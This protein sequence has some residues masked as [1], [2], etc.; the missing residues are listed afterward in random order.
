MSNMVYFLKRKDNREMTG[1]KRKGVLLVVSGFS[2]AGKGTLVQKLTKEFDN[3]ALS[4]SMTTRAPR[5]GEINGV[6]YHFV[7]DEEFEEKI[8]NNGLIEYAG[9]CRHYY[10]TPRAFVEEQLANGKDVILEIEIQGAHKVKKQY[11]DAVL[12]FVM[13]PSA[14]ELHNR[15]AGRGTETA[16]VIKERMTRAVEESE[17]IDTYDYI[18][19]NDN[20]DDCIS[21][22]NAIVN[23]ARLRPRDNLEFISE[24]QTQLKEFA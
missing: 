24:I 18:V 9:Y 22:I 10:G 13:P 15:L 1:L 6:H 7:S 8:N 14:K 12:L 3:Y 23:A 11:P 21:D 16:E 4:I 2:G 5:P 19:V 17:G 20:L